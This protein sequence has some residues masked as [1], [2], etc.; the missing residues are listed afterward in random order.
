L[1]LCACGR[2]GFDPVSDGQGDDGQGGDGVQQSGCN[3][4]AGLLL[5]DG[6]EPTSTVAWQAVTGNGTAQMSTERPHRGTRSLRAEGITGRTVAFLRAPITT[7][8]SGEIHLRAYINRPAASSATD[9]LLARVGDGIA[10]S[11]F[12]GIANGAN[13]GV[14]SGASSNFAPPALAPDTWVCMEMHVVGSQI[15]LDLDGAVKMLIVLDAFGPYSEVA[16]GL[17]ADIGSPDQLLIFVD[18]VIAATQPIGCV[19]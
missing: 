6:F 7:V 10:N 4:V 9:M 1:T 13:P 3:G 18:D 14:S 16:F 11:E 8:S 12:F 19:P 5:C 2:L 17:V 15:A